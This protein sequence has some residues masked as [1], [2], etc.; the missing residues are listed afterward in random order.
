[1]Q[2][3]HPDPTKYDSMNQ[4]KEWEGGKENLGILR[5]VNLVDAIWSEEMIRMMVV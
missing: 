1:M 3:V 4:E 2:E 5:E